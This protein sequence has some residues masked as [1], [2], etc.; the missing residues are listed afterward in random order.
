MSG[1]Y[2][3]LGSYD[4]HPDAWAP[5]MNTAPFAALD[6][7]DT[8][9]FNE[10]GEGLLIPGVSP[11]IMHFESSRGCHENCTFCAT[12]NLKGTAFRYMRTER[13]RQMLRYDRSMGIRSLAMILTPRRELPLLFSAEPLFRLNVAESQPLIGCARAVAELQQLNRP[14]R[15]VQ[16]AD[17]LGVVPCG[18][19]AD[20][21]G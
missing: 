21:C 19:S 9:A 2:M 3:R 16:Y 7:V 18:W 12:P 8:S 15:A 13:I 14:G 17:V 11:P 10:S 4:K 5:D 6:L 20:G 1:K